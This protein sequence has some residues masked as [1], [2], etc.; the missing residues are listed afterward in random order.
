MVVRPIRVLGSSGGGWLGESSGGGGL[1]SRGVVVVWWVLVGAGKRATDLELGIVGVVAPDSAW[2][3][4]VSVSGSVGGAVDDRGSW[5]FWAVG[6]VGDRGGRG[7]QRRLGGR[8]LFRWIG[9]RDLGGCAPVT[10]ERG[11]SPVT[12][13]VV[14]CWGVLAEG[15][16]R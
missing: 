5:R 7:A 4:V 1:E 13:V 14:Y 3:G 8:W 16:L 6:A 2:A 12:R 9:E 15:M 10:R 11:G